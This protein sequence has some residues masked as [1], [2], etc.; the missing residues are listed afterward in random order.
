[1]PKLLQH[2]T[3]FREKMDTLKRLDD[4][5]LDLLSAEAAID[6]EI[7]L[8]DLCR[9]KIQT[10]LFEIDE[11]LKAMSPPVPVPLPG[12]GSIVSPGI[13]APTSNKV[14]LPKL[15]LKRFNGDLTRWTAFWDS[16]ESS[17][18]HNVDLS[19]VDKF[20]YLNS[21]LEGRASEAIFGLKL[22]GANY[23]EAIEILK[24]RFGNKQQ[25]ITKHMDV[26]L[27]LEAITSQHNLKGLRYLCDLIESQVR[28]LRSLGVPSE[29]YGSLLSSVI[30][31]KLPHEIRLIVSREVA[32][33]EWEL[34]KL[35]KVVEG[36]VEARERAYI[37]NS[38]PQPKKPTPWKGPP[39]S[40]TLL[41]DGHKVE[42]CYCRQPHPSSECGAVTDVGAR[43]DI[44]KK[45]GRC[46]TCLKK[47][48]VS[49]DCRSAGRCSNCHGRHHVSICSKRHATGAR[50]TPTEPTTDNQ[51]GT[52]SVPGTPTPSGLPTTVVHYVDARTPILLQTA[53]ACVYRLDNPQS[54]ME[55]RIVLDSGS[56]KSYITER[57]KKFLSLPIENTEVML[58]K[59]FGSDVNNRQAC[60]VVR[61]GVK[62]RYG[63]ELE[64][65]FYTVPL[66]CQPLSTQPIKYAKE[67]YEHLCNLDLADW[68]N[69]A[70]DLEV[71]MLIGSDHYWRLVTGEVR[72]GEGGPTAVQTH[73]GWVLSGP[74]EGMPTS[75]HS[76]VNLVTTHILKVD[77]QLSPGRSPDLDEQLKMFWDLESLGIKE[78][79][80]SV[81]DK[82]EQSIIFRDGRYEVRLPWK[83]NRPLLPDNYR[84][85]Q[86]RLDGL[87]QRLHQKPSMLNEY[88]AIIRDQIK[89]GVVEVVDHP[90]S[91]VNG[92]IHYIPHHAVV[93]EDK[94]T[95]KLRIVYDAS[96]KSSGPS[97][98][99]CLY[100]GPKFTQNIMDI[101]IRFRVHKV[102]LAADIEKAFLMVSV[103]E[104]DRDALRF[105][106]IDDVNKD[107]RSVVVMRFSRVMFGVSSSPFLLNA[108]IKHLV[109]RYKDT[110]PG[111]VEMFLRSI[112]VDDVTFG[113]EDDEDAYHL[114]QKSKQ[115]MLE[116]GFNLRKFVTNSNQLRMKIE[117]AEQ[118][119]NTVK[120]QEA[121][122]E[123]H[124][125][126]ETYTKDTLGSKQECGEGEQ[127]ILGVSWQYLE[128]QLVFD[129]S[130]IVHVMREM[131]PTKRHIVSIATRFY[132]PLGFVSPITVKFKMFFQELCSAKVGWDE[133]LLGE[134]L[135]KWKSLMSNL[136]AISISIPRCYLS[137]LEG[138]TNHLIGFCDASANAYAAVVYLQRGTG[139]GSVSL[140]ASKTRVSPVGNRQTI[141]R[142]ELLSAL[143]LAK[144]IVSVSIALRSE[145]LLDKPAY[146]T[147]SKIAMYWIIRTER[148]W[149]PFVQNRVNDIRR[150]T[151]IDRWK[152][153]PGVDNPADIPSRGSSPAELSTSQ[154]WRHGPD[155]LKVQDWSHMSEDELEPI[156]EECL[157]EM[158][159]KE[160]SMFAHSLLVVEE[161]RRISAI[162][163]CN[164]F[165]SLQRLLRVTAYVNRFV[166][167]LKAKIQNSASQGSSDLVAGDLLEAELCWI[168][169]AQKSF[170]QEKKFSTWMHQFGLFVDSNG[171]WRCTG[172][173][174][175]ADI[176]AA[177]RHPILLP[178]KHSLTYLIV[179]DAHERIKHNGVKETLVEIRSK[180]WIIRGRQFVRWVIHRCI[181]CRRIDALP[182]RGPPPPPLPVFRVKEEP[183]F[184]Y[185]GVD[186]AGPLYIKATNIARVSKVW[187]CLYT[188][189]VSR[190]VHLD[191]VPD[192]SARTFIRSF[193]RFTA[194]RGFPRKMISDNGK[195]FKSAAK[196]IQAMLNHPEVK[197]YFSGIG[198]EWSFNLEKAPW[199]G[200]IFERLIKSM[201]QC[202]RKTIGKARLS[203][204]ELLTAITE[205]EM[206]LNSRPI[207]YVSTEDIEEPLT[208]SHLLVGHRILSLPDSHYYEDEDD[209]MDTTPDCLSRR[210]KHL[211]QTLDHF[212]KRWKSEYL[213]ELR[214]CHRYDKNRSNNL[215]PVSRG[216][217]VIVHAE[218]RPRALWRLARIE[219]LIRGSDGQVRGAT[220]R[221][222]T[223]GA[224]STLLRRP[225]QRLYPLEIHCREPNEDPDQGTR[226]TPG[227]TASQHQDGVDIAPEV[228]LRRSR[229]AATQRA[230]DRMRACAYALGL[231]SD[232]E[233]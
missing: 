115:V 104:C 202:L 213:L 78:D 207:S 141:P 111:F 65:P 112:Y 4:E 90:E 163:D 160:R 30:I 131:E 97:L 140:V 159:S 170:N 220:L 62:L 230:T 85:S 198:M 227:D 52:R 60:S 150:L 38:Q 37:A 200:G 16:F 64:L 168:R 36:E 19:D 176:P 223:R 179:R 214:N 13:H 144:L 135:Y 116:G 212:W 99:D 139:D 41:S 108:T 3:A 201:K 165:S 148:E 15:S 18:H 190:A 70:D 105:L 103:A 127:K 191:L 210:M 187:I 114:Y 217:I 14:K 126:D 216:D 66:V 219:D 178:K 142:L 130:A 12:S 83:Q 184:T 86:K 7:N 151:H 231:G 183:P 71:D 132:D 50:D 82:F 21:L 23:S 228:P 91:P 222:N 171:V 5:I 119:M 174:D 133:P 173:L 122:P 185:T 59:T 84:L 27:G 199:W 6:E 134:L 63:G 113:A 215:D 125:E 73:L 32:G 156:P 181:T 209:D 193:K 194:R 155:W 46:F 172:R 54:L 10:A 157:E 221:V 28:S 107:D 153:C 136:Q 101:I 67:R 211:N 11:V 162:M 129:L 137:G 224:R 186:F 93:R 1:M 192:L 118:E 206:I 20:N 45:S 110:D 55:I 17:I 169:E 34:D 226:P 89:K 22:T 31:N 48:H 9:E 58:I 229:R 205:V 94:L 80:C 203:Y 138:S 98:N 218:G 51:S 152:H 196:I 175:N 72:R 161:S 43:K 106:W 8:A 188:C 149:K 197:Q 117:Q 39:T 164:D 182:C 109:E 225:L 180:Y 195:T 35:M 121:N 61:L 146:F 87:L 232:C 79:E 2:Q 88:D 68:S 26:L 47:F 29:S 120:K 208:P 100:T 95:T 42:C 53:R 44:L 154:L 166:S 128:D 81:Y 167:V 177:V 102:A 56:Q 57:V 143:L 77:A 33:G 158:K 24:K 123:V 96:A 233:D 204:D 76:A 189:C 75:M 69:A 145:I 92:E 25:I 74:I 124:E 40:T 49:R 147:D